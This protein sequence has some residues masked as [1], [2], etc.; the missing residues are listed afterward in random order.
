MAS[1]TLGCGGLVETSFSRISNL[2]FRCLLKHALCSCDAWNLICFTPK[3]LLS[4]TLSL[5]PAATNSKARLWETDNMETRSF[6]KNIHIY[7][8]VR[9]EGLSLRNVIFSVTEYTAVSTAFRISAMCVCPPRLPDLPQELEMK[10]SLT[11]PSGPTSL[12]VLSVVWRGGRHHATYYTTSAA[13]PDFKRQAEPGVVGTES[14]H[15]LPQLSIS[16]LFVCLLC[17]YM[18][19]HASVISISSHGRR[20]SRLGLPLLKMVIIG[21]LV[22]VQKACINWQ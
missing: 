5:C 1:Y 15:I 11:L 6:S 14:R 3:Y 17:N 7:F 8:N 13:W 12:S 21:F 18:A 19:V 4:V 9:I 22:Y 20:F 2:S 10:L 16:R